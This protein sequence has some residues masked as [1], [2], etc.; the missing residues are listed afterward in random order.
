MSKQESNLNIL[1]RKTVEAATPEQLHVAAKKAKTVRKN[2]Y[3]IK[4][5]LNTSIDIIWKRMHKLAEQG[6]TSYSLNV[7]SMNRGN[8]DSNCFCVDDWNNITTNIAHRLSVLSG[9]EASSICWSNVDIDWS[10]ILYQ[11]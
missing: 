4:R 6:K 2:N 5:V 10:S 3:Y 7:R 11:E 1:K 9:V 8:D